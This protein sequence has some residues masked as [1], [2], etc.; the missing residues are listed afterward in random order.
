MTKPKIERKVLRIFGRVYSP[1]NWAIFLSGFV[2][3]LLAFAMIWV[4]ISAK[5]L[6]IL[7][8][9]ILGLQLAVDGYSEVKDD[10]L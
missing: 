3:L 9:M 4:D 2:V 1:A 5:L 7:T 10:E 8:L 6:A